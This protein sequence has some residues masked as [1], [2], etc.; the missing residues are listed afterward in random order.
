M[1][2][3]EPPSEE[4]TIERGGITYRGRYTVSGGIVTVTTL[5]YGHKATQV[6]GSPPLTIARILLRELVDAG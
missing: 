1:A 3:K 6:G 5:D 2:K 4:V